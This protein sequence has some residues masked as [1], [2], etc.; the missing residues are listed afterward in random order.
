MRVTVLFFG[1]LKEMLSSESQTLELPPGATVDAVLGHYRALL[2]QQPKLW[3]NAGDCREPEL[4]A[5]WLPVA[6]RR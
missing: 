1:V 4:R 6:R 3:S 2:P 5:E